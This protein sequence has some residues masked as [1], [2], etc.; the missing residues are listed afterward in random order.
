MHQVG[1]PEDRFFCVEAHKK[2]CTFSNKVSI[3]QDTKIIMV[4]VG[5]YQEMVQS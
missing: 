4:K 5:K 1:N 3:K 2:T